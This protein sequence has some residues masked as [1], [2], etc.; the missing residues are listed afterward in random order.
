MNSRKTLCKILVLALPVLGLPLTQ[1]DT[2]KVFKPSPEPVFS[3]PRAKPNIHMVFDDSASM[4]D[5]D[6]ELQG[7]KVSR[8]EALDY[9]YRA[10]MNKYKDKAYLGVSFLWQAYDHSVTYDWRGRQKIEYPSSGTGLTRLLIDDYSQKTTDNFERDVLDP[11]SKLIIN[12][13]G[14]TPMY[15]GVYEAIKMFRG[16]PTLANGVNGP[17]PNPLPVDGRYNRHN[18]FSQFPMVQ[19]IQDRS[20]NRYYPTVENKSPVR[21]RCQQNHMIVMTDGVPNDTRVWG[22]D[23]KDGLRTLGNVTSRYQVKVKNNQNSQSKHNTGYFNLSEMA[24]IRSSDVLG[25]I[26]ANVDLRNY[27][28]KATDGA[29]KLWFDDEFAVDTMPIYTH[30]V[31]LFVDP[32]SKIYTEMTKPTKGM[33]LG[34][35]KGKGN[36]EDLLSAFDTIFASIIRSTSSTLSTNDRTNS[37]ILE[38]MPSIKADGTVDMSTVGTIRYDTVYDFIPRIGAIR[39]MAPYISGYDSSIKDPDNPND[40]GKAIIATSKLWDTNETVKA[41]QGRYVTYLGGEYAGVNLSELNNAKVLTQFSSIYKKVNSEEVFD[42]NSIEWLT[43]FEKTTHPRSLRG[44]LNPLGSITNSDI[45]VANK[46]ILNINIAKDKIA[47]PLGRELTNWLLYKARYQPKNLLIVG[48]NDGFIN[49]INAQRGLTG[50]HKGGQRDTA[51]FPKMLVHRFDEIAKANTNP[52]LVMESKTNLVDAKVYQPTQDGGEHIYATIGLT[53]MGGGGKGLVGY[54]IYADQSAEVDDW[55]SKNKPNGSPKETSI[56]HK[57][58]PL[59]EIT[60]EGPKELRTDGF[61]DLG[62]TYSGFEFFNRIIEQSNIF[63]GKTKLK[64][65][66]VAIFGNGFG[67]DSGKSVLYFIDAYTGKKL[68]EI[69]LDSQGLGAG[70]PSIIVAPGMNGGQE[71]KRIYVGDYSGSL[72]KIEFNGYDFENNARITTLFKVPQTNY[73]QSAISVKPLVVKKGKTNLYNIYFGTGLAASYDLDRGQN[74]LVQ[75]NVYAVTDNNTNISLS[76]ENL[77]FGKM[78]YGSVFEEGKYNLELTKPINNPYGWYFPLTADSH[79]SGERVIQSPKYDSINDDIIFATWGIKERTKQDEV[80]GLD[81][82]CIADKA[83]GKL[84]SLDAVTGNGSSRIGFANKGSVVTASGGIT[85]GGITDAPEGNTMTKLSDLEQE[86]QEEVI[87]I[88]GKESSSNVTEDEKK[89]FVCSGDLVGTVECDELKPISNKPVG[90][91][92]IRLSIQ[93]LFS[94]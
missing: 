3:T 43:N 91:D 28:E 11:I 94:S 46:D 60:N 54:R 14:N 88:V 10:L 78:E 70:T 84:I 5:V 34:F 40:K 55:V 39:A 85:G 7:R 31:S 81:D 90:T 66:A 65:Q 44:R 30:S 56:Y 86:M 61:E 59:F 26:T 62:Y 83:F 68:H 36:A 52:T 53:A 49:F 13:P 27:A 4:Q 20:K 18:G 79:A 73:G 82:P 80:T 69:V 37:D 89:K 75:H 38:Q 33:N 17:N 50:K 22:I 51:Y 15:P 6:I 19:L 45:V 77:A 71:L 8:A 21:F 93:T 58:T 92:P 87:A 64:G 63:G 47:S 57:V 67:S 42:K 25:K 24:E 41:N 48:D 1:A 32:Y 74:S 23:E 76:I 35:A 72:Y 16:Q 12:S 9:T 2:S 29:G